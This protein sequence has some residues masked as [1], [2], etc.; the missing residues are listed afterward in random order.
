MSAADPIPLDALSDENRAILSLLL[1]Q[2][3][4]YHEIAELLR[5]DPVRVRERA[6]AAIESLAPTQPAHIAD[7]LV[8]EQSVSERAL[9]RSQLAGSEPERAWAAG[10]ALAL[11]P[12]AEAALPA[13]PDPDPD[14]SPAPAAM[15]PAAPDPDPPVDRAK[16]QRPALTAGLGLLAAAAVAVILLV[17]LSGG[18]NGHRTPAVA[19]NSG[20]TIK[21]LILSSAGA[22]RNASGVA[23]IVRPARGGLLLEL[24]GRGLPANQNGSYAVWLFNKPGDSRLLGFISPGVGA[25]GAFS[26]GTVLPADAARFHELVVTLETTSQPPTP[27]QAVLKGPLRLP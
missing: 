21:R 3:R 23:R 11:A 2:G 7:Y 18:G 22:D 10:I 14:P 20:R 16:R 17:G 15:D 27:G 6:H 25:A 13:I 9:T 19:T 4:S 8:G 12:L 26:S 24:Q 5:L 1:V